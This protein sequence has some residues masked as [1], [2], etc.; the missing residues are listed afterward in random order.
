MDSKWSTRALSGAD[1][2]DASGPI[3]VR[4]TSATVPHAPTSCSAR[5]TAACTASEDTPPLGVFASFDSVAGERERPRADDRED[6]EDELRDEEDDERGDD[7]EDEVDEDVED[8]SPSKLESWADK[9]D[10][11]E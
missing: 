6:E 8:V 11:D 2:S 9:M 7:E 4:S 3:R 5:L 1:A 10:D